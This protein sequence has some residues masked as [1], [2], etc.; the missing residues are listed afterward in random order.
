VPFDHQA[1]SPADWCGRGG[2]RGLHHDD[3]PDLRRLRPEVCDRERGVWPRLDRYEQ[4]E[5]PPP[6]YR[7]TLASTSAEANRAL[8]DLRACGLLHIQKRRKSTPVGTRQAFNRYT[9]LSQ[10]TPRVPFGIDLSLMF[11]RQPPPPRSVS[12]GVSGA[13]EYK[14][15]IVIERKVTGCTSSLLRTLREQRA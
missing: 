2:C 12:Q 4:G 10:A 15:E 3:A 8:R 5:W 6:R 1:Y 7:S 13:R 11:R 9:V 14:Q